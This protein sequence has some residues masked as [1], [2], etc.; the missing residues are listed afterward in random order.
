MATMSRIEIHPACDLWM[1]GDRYGT[2][3]SSSVNRKGECV[4]RVRMDISRKV[5]KV[6]DALIQRWL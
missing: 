2:V 3:E 5:I 4:Y 1:R 6:T